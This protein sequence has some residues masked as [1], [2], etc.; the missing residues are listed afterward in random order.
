MTKIVHQEWFSDSAARRVM[1]AL[2]EAGGSPRYVGGCV[3]NA[4]LNV[5]VDDI[6]IATTLEPTA[7]M[8]ALDAKGIKTVP[9]GIEHGT[10]TAVIDGKPFEVTTLR[11]DI[12]TDGRRAVVAYTKDWA[13]D[14]GRRDFTLNAL[15]ADLSGNVFD[16]TGQGLS[17]LE[18]GRVR[19]IGDAGKRIQEDYLRIL[20]FF[21]IHAYYGR[22]ELDL[23]GLAACRAHANGIERLSGER[24]QKEM[25]R[26]LSAEASIAALRAMAATGILGLIAPGQLNFVRYEAMAANEQD[27]FMQPVPILRVAALLS[28]GQGQADWIADR[29]RLSNK[30]A[31]RLHALTA[32]EQPKIVSYLSIKEVR[33]TLYRIGTERFVDLCKLRWAEDK[34]ASNQ[35]QWR[36]LIAMAESWRRPKLP[37]SGAQVMHAGVPAG[38]DVGRVLAEVEEWWIDADFTDDEFSIVERLKA[39]VQATI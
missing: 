32:I 7:A 39:V 29:W 15:Y 19:F 12:E 6:D 24:I 10:V 37:L 11:S 17:D 9:T 33:R 4:L 23:A 28:P 13:E 1:G 22:G 14:A 3:R 8:A 38:P 2:E 34:K 5:P 21:R 26:L 35:M 16:P 27:T 31:E 25:L 30:D 36:A 18:F 20:R